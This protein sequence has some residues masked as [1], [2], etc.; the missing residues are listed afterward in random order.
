[1]ALTTQQKDQIY[2]GMMRYCSAKGMPINGLLKTDFR[3][4]VDSV[5]TWVDANMGAY[6]SALPALAQTNLTS[7]EKSLF[8]IADVLMR[9]DIALLKQIFGEV[10]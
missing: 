1:M 4:I 5:D 10:D 3:A 9:F 7:Q 6:N 8:L 2:R